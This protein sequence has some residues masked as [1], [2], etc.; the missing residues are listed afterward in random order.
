MTQ[1]IRYASFHW[2]F[3][4][5]F[6]LEVHLKYVLSVSI[7]LETLLKVQNKIDLLNTEYHL[8]V[9]VGKGCS[10]LGSLY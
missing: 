1:F 8:Y 6:R 7:A 10:E 9:L 4:G 5:T 3:K 2:T